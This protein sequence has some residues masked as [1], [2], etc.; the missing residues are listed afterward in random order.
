[1]KKLF[2]LLTIFFLGLTSCNKEETSREVNVYMPDGTPALALASMLDEGFEYE[3][4]KTTFHIVTASEIAATVSQSTCDLAIMPTTA[5]ATLYNKGIG[6]QL[7]SVNVFGNLFIVGTKE[8][9]S[10]EDLKGKVI[11]T[12]A[13]TTIQMVQYVLDANNIEYT[14]GAEA[15][16]G[17][18]ALNSVGDATEIIANLKMGIQKGTEAYGVLGE[19]QVTKVQGMIAGLNINFDLQKEYKAITGFDGYPQ[20]CLIVKK[21]FA[22]SYSGYVEAFLNKLEYNTNY[23]NNNVTKLPNVF[24]KYDSSLAGMSFTVDTITRCNLRLELAS[25]VKDSVI[26]YVKALAKI[27]LNNEFFYIQ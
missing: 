18:V 27:D 16:E 2:L 15:V 24:A 11:Y 3:N 10:L 6:L 26:S 12:T 23:L 8:T 25:S 19:P 14:D 22:E 1:M 21:S 17:K 4:V 5:A 13:A 7:A 20:A 9:T